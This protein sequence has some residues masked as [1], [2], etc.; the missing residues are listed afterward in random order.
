LSVRQ[1]FDGGSYDALALVS[2]YDWADPLRRDRSATSFG[3][4]LGAGMQAGTALFDQSRLGLEWEHT[5]NRLVSQRFRV[6]ATL[7]LEVFR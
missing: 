5:L 4:V 2:L 7:E 6:L 3:Y 1:S